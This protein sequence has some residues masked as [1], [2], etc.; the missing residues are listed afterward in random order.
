[1]KGKLYL[2]FFRRVLLALLL[3]HRVGRWSLVGA[4]QK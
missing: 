4:W 1:L 3:R 2:T